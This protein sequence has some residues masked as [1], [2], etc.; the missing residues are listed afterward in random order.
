MIVSPSRLCSVPTLVN[1]SPTTVPHCILCRVCDA[2]SFPLA[3][4]CFVCSL[5]L[6]A[7]LC[8]AIPGAMLGILAA[9]LGGCV[10]SVACVA[11]VALLYCQCVP[12]CARLLLSKTV[13]RH[14][15][16]QGLEQQS[17][18]QQQPH[19]ALLQ[20]PHTYPHACSDGTADGM[21]RMCTETSQR[22]IISWGTVLGQR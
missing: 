16:R 4:L 10:G 15:G 21:L 8:V 11:A 19:A 7:W 14:C 5:V 12:V 6:P 22:H 17:K 18:T 2:V 9:M 20:R 3:S 1:V 13:P